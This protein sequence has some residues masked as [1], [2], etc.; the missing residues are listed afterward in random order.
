MTS[1]PLRLYVCFTIAVLLLII[2]YYFILSNI[3]PY[4]MLRA[5]RISGMHDGQHD[6]KQIHSNSNPARRRKIFSPSVDKSN[7]IMYHVNQSLVRDIHSFKSQL[8]DQLMHEEKVFASQSAMHA[9]EDADQDAMR[10]NRFSLKRERLCSIQFR[11]LDP[12]FDREIV[13]HGVYRVLPTKK[14][15]SLISST[16]TSRNKNRHASCA[17]VSSAASIVGSLS[18][19]SIDTHDIILR[20]NAALT[21]DEA[22]NDTGARTSIRIFNSHFFTSN[23]FNFSHPLFDGQVIVIWDN[24]TTNNEPDASQLY[25]KYVFYRD[26]YPDVRMYILNPMAIRQAVHILRN[27]SS[28]SLPAHMQPSSGFI[29][30]LFLMRFCST[31]TAYEFI[32][33]IRMSSRCRY[34]DWRESYNCTFGGTRSSE[35]LFALHFNHASDHN[36]IVRGRS[37]YAGCAR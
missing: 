22:G 27:S 12:T 24:F 7:S 14:L 8:V 13:E 2:F 5:G 26:N 4:P 19:K 37:D 11:G 1:F 20:F 10:R 31:V 17:L 6:W 21:G 34:Y 3:D 28:T 30:L 23:A 16:V 33:S 29:G 18:G 9:D 15:D 36:V 32:P 25:K 35:K